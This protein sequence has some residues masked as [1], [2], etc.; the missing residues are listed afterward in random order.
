M[1]PPKYQEYFNMMYDDLYA[2]Q[3][4]SDHPLMQYTAMFLLRRIIFVL[5]AFY[6]YQPSFTPFQ[7]LIN[8]QMNFLFNVYL[9]AY[10]PLTD[11]S[12][13]RLN[14]INELFFLVLCY[15][16]LAF[17]DFNQS[18]R[19]KFMMGW[20]FVFVSI[21]NFFWP[22]IY[23]VIAEAWPAVILSCTSKKVDANRKLGLHLKNC[24]E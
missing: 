6:L 11:P 1:K 20:S 5:L 8:I 19:A 4:T 7:V 2:E 22:N 18:V 17:T 12:K 23:L 16:Q 21:F 10:N 15:H 14:I 13:N 9:V 3:K 24:E